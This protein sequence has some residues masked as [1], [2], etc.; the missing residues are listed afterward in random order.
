M[1]YDPES[2]P[3]PPAAHADPDSSG[4]DGRPEPAA[5]AYLVELADHDSSFEASSV[6]DAADDEAS[7][8]KT[9]R[10]RRKPARKTG[11]PSVPAWGDIMFGSRPGTDRS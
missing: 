2:M 5:A 7:D 3:P 11:R 1:S 8:D 10:A 9:P 6:S 4:P